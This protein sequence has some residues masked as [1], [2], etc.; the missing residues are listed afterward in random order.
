MYIY[1]WI[2]VIVLCAVFEVVTIGLTTVW[3]A[4]GGAVALLLAIFAVSPGFQA[5]AFLAVSI[6]L[7]VLTRPLLVKRLRLGK[8]KT[9]VDALIGVVGLVTEDIKELGTGQVRINGQLWTARTDQESAL[10]K[11][12]RIQVDRVEGVK[13]VVSP[14]PQGEESQHA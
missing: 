1:F 7:L 8:D 6:P 5:L 10:A 3:F 12:T 9:N 14:V 13:L 4:I 11:D 2:A